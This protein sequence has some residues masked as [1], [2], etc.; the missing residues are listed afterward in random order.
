MSV[1]MEH[2]LKTQSR[3][4]HAMSTQRSFKLCQPTKQSFNSSPSVSL[5]IN[6]MYF[7]K[8]YKD[9]KKI[10]LTF[11]FHHKLQS[12]CNQTGSQPSKHALIPNPGLSQQAIPAFLSPSLYGWSHP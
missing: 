4:Q 7:P 12:Q 9:I 8:T 11:E 6:F 10:L 3:S 5:S 2:K 1:N